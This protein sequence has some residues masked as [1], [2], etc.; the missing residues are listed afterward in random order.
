MPLFGAPADEPSDLQVELDAERAAVAHWRRVARQRSEELAALRNR[1]P[2]RVLLGVERRLEPVVSVVGSARRRVRPAAERLALSTGALRR[3]AG[4]R[5]PSATPGVPAPAPCSGEPP[6]SARPAAIVVVGAARPAWLDALPAGVDI[7][8]SAAPS[9][10][11]AAIAAAVAASDPGVV[12]IIHAAAEPLTP[13]W[14]ERLV[15]AVDGSAVAAVPVL[16]HPHRP[17][18][19]ATAHDGLV[20][21]AGVGLRL[22]GDGTPVAELVDAGSASRPGGATVDVT[23][24]SGAALVVDRT[25]YE[26][27]GGLAPGDDLDAAAVEL[28]VRLRAAGGRVVLVP[29]AV[30]VDHRPVRTRQELR[31]AVNPAG[32]GWAA[33]I[34]RSGALVR[35]AAERTAAPPVRVDGRPDPALRFAI[36]VAAPS[37]KVASRWGDWHL[38]QALAESLRRLGHKARLQT[39]D[40]ADDLAGRAS[41][42][43]LVL[44]GLQPVRR[45]FGQRHVLWIISHPESIDDG[46]LDAADLVLV[47][48]PRFAAHLKHRT[49]TPVEAMLQATDHRRFCPRPVDPT[50]RHDVTIVAKTR[51]VMRPVVSDA[52]AVGLRPAI[53]GGGWRGLVDPDLVV[54]EHVDNET[55]PVVYSSAGIVLNDHWRTMRAWG[56]VSNR[57]FDVLACGTPV[58]SDPVDGMDELFERAVLEYHSPD[59]LRALVDE[60]L[61]EPEAARQH[62]ERGRKVVLAN[63]TFDHRARQLLDRLADA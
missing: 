27:V 29:G 47:A 30:V 46:E 7:V 15:A 62:A 14:L 44:R 31:Y 35:R 33:A 18:R 55:L 12:G 32:R 9:G 61:T 39:A 54:A 20:R 41:D 45:T 19:R 28:C 2:V 1:L 3:R 51:E 48:S 10:T 5:T 4:R 60:V 42:V 40:R 8:G 59:E 37:A 21:A 34:D 24:G 38:A 25:A 16:V 57:L 22:D 11:R 53:Y 63:H 52:L 43:H 17:L 49:S 6:P 50:H 26:A 36:T 56:F 13:D 23:A 58:I